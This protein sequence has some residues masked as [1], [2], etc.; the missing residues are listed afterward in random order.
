MKPLGQKLMF[1]DFARQTA[2]LHVRIAILNR[3]TAPGI[4]VTQPI[5]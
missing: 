5:N 1:R 2:E 3:F 4:L